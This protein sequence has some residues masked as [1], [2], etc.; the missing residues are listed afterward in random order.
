MALDFD[1]E[2]NTESSPNEVLNEVFKSAGFSQAN[3]ENGF[4]TDGV[5]GGVISQKGKSEYYA[6][7]HQQMLQANFGFQSTIKVWFRPDSYDNYEIGMKNGL[8]A[9]LSVLQNIK[10]DAVVLMNGEDIKLIRK[11][12][13]LILNSES[14]SADDSIWTFDQIPFP[15]ET[16]KLG[17]IE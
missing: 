16:K 12:D 1:L 9:F 17:V 5:V 15:F 6:D 10:G 7:V 4:Y 3:Y 8:K 2:I 13:K 14:F 11:D